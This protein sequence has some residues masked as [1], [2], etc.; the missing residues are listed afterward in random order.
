MLSIRSVSNGRII[1]E[2]QG[3]IKS[4]DRFEK[5]MQEVENAEGLQWN[6]RNGPE[7]WGNYKDFMNDYITYN[8]KE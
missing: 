2:K 6:Y 3:V 5:Y 4:S 8:Y 1:F 7:E